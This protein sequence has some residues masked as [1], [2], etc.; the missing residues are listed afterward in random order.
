MAQ[1]FFLR[2]DINSEKLLAELKTHKNKSA[3]VH[4]RILPLCFPDPI[5]KKLSG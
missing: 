3:T 5:T 2:V 4:S 1:W